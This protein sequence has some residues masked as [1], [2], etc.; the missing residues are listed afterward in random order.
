MRTGTEPTIYLAEAE[1]Q[2]PIRRLAWEGSPCCCRGASFAWSWNAP[3]QR[4]LLTLRQ[5][6]HP[7]AYTKTQHQ[8]RYFS[9]HDLSTTTTHSFYPSN[10]LRDFH[11][12]NIPSFHFFVPLL[13]HQHPS[14]DPLRFPQR[15]RPLS[16]CPPPNLFALRSANHGPSQLSPLQHAPTQL[17]RARGL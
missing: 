2:I 4:V 11:S 15:I 14:I 7:K 16:K 13:L 12:S 1:R 5:I 6:S 9:S 17:P 3:S 8:K 10:P